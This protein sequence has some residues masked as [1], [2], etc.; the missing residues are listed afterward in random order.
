MDVR[1]AE[2]NKLVSDVVERGLSR[3]FSSRHELV[4]QF[5]ENNFSIKPA[6]ELNKKAFGLDMLK[7]PL[8][9]LWTPPHF[10]LSGTGRILK[11]VSNN[12]LGDRLVKLPAGIKTDVEQEVAWRVQTQLLE[13][14]YEQGPRKFTENRMLAMILEDD[15]LN[16][17]FDQS[18]MQLAD[19]VGNESGQRALAEKLL[20]YVDSRKAAAELSS[21]FVALAAG[22][23]ANKSVN[24]GAMGLGSVLAAGIAHNVAVS[25]FV[26]G[27]TLGGLYYSVFTASASKTM[28]ALSTG[29]VAVALGVIASYTG[30]VTDP[31]QKH[32]GMHQKKLHKVI[33]KLEQQFVAGDKSA[34]QF[35]DGFVARFLDLADLMLAVTVK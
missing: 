22:Y 3:Y 12:R 34:M 16:A 2:N 17:L 23:A 18:L 14:P 15:K 6:F 13:L 35:K 7:T 25:S 28:I 27:N 33:D 26:L 1:T 5:V 19:L 4:D 20:V 10:L 8:N 31:L 30:F 24:F 21:A 11:R 29:G 9:I 32:F